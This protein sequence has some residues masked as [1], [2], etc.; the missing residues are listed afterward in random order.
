MKRRQ[1]IALLGGAAAVWPLAAR[2]QQPGKVSRIGYLS[3]GSATIGPL[4]RHDAFL[5]GLR[6][7]GYVEGKNFVIEYRFAEGKFDRLSD[8]AEL[9]AGRA[10]IPIIAMGST[11]ASAGV[12]LS[13]FTY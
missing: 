7:L 3:P 12:H 11:G 9:P 2:A 5:Q 10:E 6:D 1:F 13:P 4:A 8:L